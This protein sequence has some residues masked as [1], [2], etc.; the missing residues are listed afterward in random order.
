MAGRWAPIT[1]RRIAAQPSQQIIDQDAWNQKKE[2]TAQRWRTQANNTR[3]V[4]HRC[5]LLTI[6]NGID[7]VLKRK[8][9]TAW[10]WRANTTN[11]TTLAT[12]EPSPATLAFAILCKVSI[13][14]ALMASDLAVILFLRRPLRII[15]PLVDPLA[16]AMRPAVVEPALLGNIIARLPTGRLVTRPKTAITN[17]G[18]MKTY[19]RPL[20]PNIQNT[21]LAKHR[22]IECP[23]PPKD[24]FRMFAHMHANVKPCPTFVRRGPPTPS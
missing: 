4:M 24:V 8:N 11:P 9:D 1:S 7:I 16:I 15:I 13:L 20:I 17:K 19:C 2:S 23:R 6:G 18:G 5:K 10:Q 22:V 21:R 3:A 14:A 12:G